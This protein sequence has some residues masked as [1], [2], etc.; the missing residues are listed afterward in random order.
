MPVC[1]VILR[2]Q[3]IYTVIQAVHSLLYIVAKCHFFSVLIWKHIIKYLQTCEGCTDFCEILHPSV[4]LSVFTY[5]VNT[6]YLSIISDS[7][8]VRLF[9][10]PSDKNPSNSSIKRW[11]LPSIQKYFCLKII[12]KN[13][14][15]QNPLWICVICTYVRSLIWLFLFGIHFTSWKIENQQIF[16]Y[17]S[18]I[19][20]FYP[21]DLRVHLHWHQ[22][23]NVSN[24]YSLHSS[25]DSAIHSKYSETTE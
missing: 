7:S 10:H 3:Q 15:N 9:V 6:V 22:T 20:W 21:C 17:P 18:S 12:L 8:S 19:D 4:C 24:F 13:K 25:L 16:L 14:T 1:W 5:S 11:V 2:E 23:H